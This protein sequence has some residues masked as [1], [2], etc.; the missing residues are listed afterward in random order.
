MLTIANIEARIEAMEQ[1]TALHEVEQFRER[2]DLLDEQ[3][4]IL[5][6]LAVLAADQPRD[7]H[8][9]ALHARAMVLQHMLASKNQ[10]FCEQLRAR[11]AAGSY[12]R[13]VLLQTF[14]GNS[15]PHPNDDFSYDSLD[16]LINGLVRADQPP[17]TGLVLEREMVGYQPTP[18]RLIVEL[19]QRAQLEH[20]DTFFDVGSGLGHVAVVVAL[21]SGARTVGIEVDAGY[22]AYARRCAAL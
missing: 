18:A 12:D 1:H 9:S 16:V 8:I 5:D 6:A 17:E 14:M 13:D 15:S 7:T 10:Q 4:Q 20:G 3:E 2:A 21:L 22:C 19:V 11:I